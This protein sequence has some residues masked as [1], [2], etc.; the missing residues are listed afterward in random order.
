MRIAK[1]K[2]ESEGDALNKLHEEYH[3]FMR[4]KTKQNDFEEG[5]DIVQ[6]VFSVFYAKGYTREEIQS[7]MKLHYQ[8]LENRHEEG[9]INIESWEEY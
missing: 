5:F 7:H 2:T 9:R 4:S 8:K 3:E 6:S 1:I